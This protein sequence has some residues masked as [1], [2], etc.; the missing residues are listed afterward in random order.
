[1]NA[2]NQGG[3]GQRPYR[4]APNQN[5]FTP[6]TKGG[7]KKRRVNKDGVLT[8]LFVALIA[9][10]VIV[11]IVFLV[12]AIASS[13]DPSKTTEP[14]QTATT[15]AQTT[16]TDPSSTSSTAPT[17]TTQSGGV[18]G[19]AAISLSQSGVFNGPLVIINETNQ[20]T[21]PT[22]DDNTLTSLYNQPGFK[23]SYRLKN[24]HVALR[25]E[26]IEQFASMINMLKSRFASTS[27]AED[28][29]LITNA[30]T[31]NDPSAVL[32]YS[33]E[34]ISGYSFDIRVYITSTGKNRILNKDEQ[35]WLADNCA[36]YGFVLRYEEGK[37]DTTG[38]IAD[39]YHFR[40]VGIPHSTYMKANGLC[41]EEYVSLIK[42]YT[43]KSPLTIT[44][45]AKTYDVY[46]VKLAGPAT[47]AYV[48][49]GAVY[50]VSGNNVD[51]FIITVEK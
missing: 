44:S 50:T 7:N 25:Y 34:N 29:L 9:I 36:K 18:E 41:L 38:V 37:E 21:I 51:G 12:K 2:N 26:I 31:V 40:Y 17:G 39:L 27:L 43:Y 42:N 14:S 3:Y 19:Y 16:A 11:L 22:G 45:G 15:P 49:T 6:R 20:Y 5:G 13:G 24:S 32:D 4:Q 28:Y 8:L 10:I 33:D 47:T 48:P 46:Y 23:T 30:G 35:A 1:M